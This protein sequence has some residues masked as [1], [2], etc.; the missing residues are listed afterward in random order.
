MS[1]RDFLIPVVLVFLT[2]LVGK[3]FG[4][5]GNAE[6]DNPLAGFEPLIGGEWHLENSFQVYEWGVGQ[7]SIKAKGYFLVDGKPKLVSEGLWFWHPGEKKIK[8][9]FTAINM[10]VVF[11]DYTT[12]FEGADVVSELQSYSISGKE[13]RYIERYEFVD[14]NRYR[15]SLVQE[16][17]EG[18]KQ[19]MGGMFERK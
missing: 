19:V 11:F 9:Y 17:D 8:G 10:P 7:K 4:G 14:E 16:T 3:I 13:M 6:T 5:G 12:R 1:K 2:I 15:W 18:L